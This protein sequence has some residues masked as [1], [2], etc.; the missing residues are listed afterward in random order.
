M[1]NGS[2]NRAQ[3]LS[4]Q[5]KRQATQMKREKG[6]MEKEGGH[7]GGRGQGARG[8]GEKPVQGLSHQFS[9]HLVALCPGDSPF[10]TLLSEG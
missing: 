9:W 7:I 8:G 4:K 3:L 6:R 2:A 5:P 10:A 1:N